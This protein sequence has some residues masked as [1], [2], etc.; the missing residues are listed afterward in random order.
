MQNADSHRL[1]TERVKRD[2][3]YILNFSFFNHQSTT[4]AIETHFGFFDVRNPKLIS[5]QILWCRW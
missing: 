1:Q 5:E 2:V 3:W 4:S